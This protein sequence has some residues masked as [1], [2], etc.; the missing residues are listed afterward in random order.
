MRLFVLLTAVTCASACTY[1]Q[2]VHVHPPSAATAAK[3]TLKDEPRHPMQD[4]L[5][6][7]IRIA[8]VNG[9]C[10]GTV[11]GDRLVITS[12]SCFDQITTAKT[13]SRDRVRARVGGGFV[14]WRIVPVMAVLSAPCT[15]IAVMVTDE[16]IPDADPLRMRL[17]A[18]VAIGEPVRV[19]GY[20]RCSGNAYGARVVSPQGYVRELSE[21]TF[22]TNVPACSGDAG[23]PIISDWTG[24]VV[25]VLQGEP[26]TADK[27]EPTSSVAGSVARVDV[28]RG[29]LAQ[30]F[31]VAHG[32]E[33]EHLPPISC[34]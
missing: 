19:V 34:Q 5:D 7:V 20:G 32:V 6:A 22:Q 10:A 28:A 15:G 24:E 33:A 29:L 13:F 16:P 26:V 11:I 14:P 8:S 25:G 3:V 21:A 12:R 23:G 27:N 31:L 30:A 17:G 9:E 4:P 18:E 2:H 1:E